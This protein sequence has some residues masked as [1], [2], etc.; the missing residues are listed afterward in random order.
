MKKHKTLFS[1]CEVILLTS[2]EINKILLPSNCNFF[3]MKLFQ[4]GC[5]PVKNIQVPY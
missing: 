3:E 4:I 1:V 5:H 2:Q